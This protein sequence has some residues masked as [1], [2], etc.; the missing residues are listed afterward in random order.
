[1]GL[2]ISLTPAHA[3]AG[4]LRGQVEETAKPLELGPPVSIVDPL[5][6]GCSW[7]LQSLARYLQ[8]CPSLV[9]TIEWKQLLNFILFGDACRCAGGGWTQLSIGLLNHGT[10]GRTP[11][12]FWAIG[13]AVCG[14][15]DLVDGC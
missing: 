12:H 6:S 1:M 5:T 9:D 14:D 2:L 4:P 3:L 13:I 7:P 15:K 10:Q 11:A 8:S